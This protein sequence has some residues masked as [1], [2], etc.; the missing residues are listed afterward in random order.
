MKDAINYKRENALKTIEQVLQATTQ[1]LLDQEDQKKDSNTA[2]KLCRYMVFGHATF[3]S[4]ELRLREFALPSYAGTSFLTLRGTL[5]RSYGLH[6]DGVNTAH[7]PSLKWKIHSRSEWDLKAQLLNV[8]QQM[9]TEHWGLDYDEFIKS[10][11]KN[12]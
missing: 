2:A 10:Q 1:K 9:D 11:A 4:Q 8:V 7:N 6:E 12:N 3:L 5:Q